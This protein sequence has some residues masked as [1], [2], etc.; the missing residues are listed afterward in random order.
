MKTTDLFKIKKPV[1]SCEVFPPKKSGT[2]EGVIRALAD[3]KTVAPDFVSITYGASGNGGMS[4]SDVASIALDAFS[5]APVAHI[6][7]VNMTK[8]RVDEQLKILK[9]KNIENILVL[10]GD[11]TSESAFYDFF[12]ANELAS[13]I[14]SVDSSF[15]LLGACYPEGHYEAK[16]LDED[17]SYLS[18]KIE[19]GVSHLITQLFFD[20]NKFYEFSEK[21]YKANIKVPVQAGIMPIT[22]SGQIK[23]IVSMCGAEIPVKFAHLLA[24]YG[25]T[26][27]LYNAGMGFAEEQIAD[28]IENGVD[29]IHLY[30]M[31][32]GEVAV[33]IFDGI[34]KQWKA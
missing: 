24:K 1:L 28:L 34:K 5:M 27:E 7:S 14:K 26:P 9:N 30:T 32:K 17:I 8:E 25:D 33:R 11:I 29:G 12:H 31:N 4:T 19:A 23:R 6:T 16:S 15:N 21:L 20:N 22:A 10:R 2:L 13:Y 3:I 18:K